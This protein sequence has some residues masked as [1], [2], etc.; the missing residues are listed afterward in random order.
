MSNSFA[1]MSWE[2]RSLDAAPPAFLWGLPSKFKVLVRRFVAHRD[3]KGRAL[4]R[5]S[6]RCPAIRATMEF[7]SAGPRLASLAVYD[8][9][10]SNPGRAGEITLQVARPE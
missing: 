3:C 5:A 1:R 10:Y 8:G 4:P 2:P 9:G 7:R 6:E